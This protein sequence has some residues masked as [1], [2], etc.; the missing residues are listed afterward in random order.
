MRVGTGTPV[1]LDEGGDP[2]ELRR[3][4]H[5]ERAFTEDFIQ[6][7]VIRYPDVLPA[8]EL[9][10]TKTPLIPIGREIATDVGPIDA[11]FVSPS[12]GITIVEAKLWRNPESR[13]EVV[14]QIID[15]AQNLST[16]SYERLDGICRQATGSSLWGLASAQDDSRSPEAEAAFVD[17][18]AKSLRDGRFLL[19][20]VGDGIREEVERMASYVQSSPQLQ[21]HLALIELRIFESTTGQVRVVVPS[22]VARTAEVS[23]AVVTVEVAE[24][25]R[26]AV[27]VSVPSDDAPRSRQRLSEDEFLGQ[28]RD[29]AC[30]SAVDELFQFAHVRGLV[31]NIG[32]RGASLR[33]PIE[34]AA[35]PLT[36]AWLNPPGSVGWMGLKD[37]TLGFDASSTL[38]RLGQIPGVL[39]DYVD[40]AGALPGATKVSSTHIKGWQLSP[41]TIVDELER[42]TRLLGAAAEGLGLTVV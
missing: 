26:V 24:E 15:Y 17:T 19:L 7:L 32:D 6:D 27:S 20:V 30:R 3:V 36:V 12:G 14:G 18:V 2:V 37:L 11:V 38:N 5:E 23:R 28:F 9:D 16:W 40:R 41:E 10:E 35:T 31:V 39:T 8:A 4:S 13:R 34:A 33:V 25:A 21:F 22:V 29:P 42:V 1:L